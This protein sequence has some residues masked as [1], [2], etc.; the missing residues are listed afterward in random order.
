MLIYKH[1]GPHTNMELSD[2]KINEAQTLS[3]KICGETLKSF[4]L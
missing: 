3:A 4:M 2:L 1:K